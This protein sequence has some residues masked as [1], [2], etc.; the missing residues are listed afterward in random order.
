MWIIYSLHF[1][2]RLGQCKWYG[3]FLLYSWF[4]QFSTDKTV[5][6][7]SFLNM[8]CKWNAPWLVKI[9]NCIITMWNNCGPPGKCKL[10]N[11]NIMQQKRK[12]IL[13]N[14]LRKVHGIWNHFDNFKIILYEVNKR[15][16]FLITSDEERFRYFKLGGKHR[17]K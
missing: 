1:L 7:S 16:H 11:M 6:L 14:N 8:I 9:T 4:H 17:I 15:L 3:E 10:E 5:L 12:E 13:T 2:S